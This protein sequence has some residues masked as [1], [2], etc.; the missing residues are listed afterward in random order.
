MKT[1]WIVLPIGLVAALALLACEPDTGFVVE[2][3]SPSELSFSYQPGGRVQFRVKAEATKSILTSEHTWG[4][5]LIATDESGKVLFD[6]RIS[7]NELMQRKRVIVEAGTTAPGDSVTP[8]DHKPA[9]GRAPAVPRQPQY[10]QRSL[11]SVP[12]E[13]PDSGASP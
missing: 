13:T 1:L 11:T 4:G 3:R 8:I 10:E 5:R 9:F 2:N 7:W 6:E 12:Q